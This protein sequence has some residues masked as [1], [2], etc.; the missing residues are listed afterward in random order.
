MHESQILD[1]VDSVTL[2]SLSDSDRSI[3]VAD[4]KSECSGQRLA[5]NITSLVMQKITDL[6][7]GLYKESQTVPKTNETLKESEPDGVPFKIT[8]ESE[9]NKFLDKMMSKKF[10]GEFF[11]DTYKEVHPV[12]NF[13]ADGVPSHR[14]DFI[15]K[16]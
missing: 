2:G 7:N 1:I 6:G 14:S 13:I 12:E 9:I 5:S 11:N 16:V 3:I 10:D 4:I 8:N 15:V